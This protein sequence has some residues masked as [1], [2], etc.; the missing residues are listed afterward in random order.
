MMFSLDKG[1]FPACG[2]LPWE[3][4][5]VFLTVSVS[6]ALR[7]NWNKVTN[8]TTWTIKKKKLV[9]VIADSQVPKRR[10]EKKKKKKNENQTKV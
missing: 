1:S 5:S 10:K 3:G 4:A 7:V 6:R 9:S 2:P 8:N